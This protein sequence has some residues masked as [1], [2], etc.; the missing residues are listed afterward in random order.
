MQSE[1]PPPH[2]SRGVSYH[3][4]VEAMAIEGMEIWMAPILL[5]VYI[6][7]G[8]ERTKPTPAGKKTAR[9]VSLVSS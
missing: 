5:R 8:L 2:N 7:W 1:L 9:M 4:F 3:L 6:Q